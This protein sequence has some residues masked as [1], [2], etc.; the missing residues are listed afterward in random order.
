MRLRFVPGS[1]PDSQAL[2]VAFEVLVQ[3]KPHVLCYYFSSTYIEVTMDMIQPK[4]L[5]APDEHEMLHAELDCVPL[6]LSE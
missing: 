5:G 2:M 3:E 1:I 6:F 4:L